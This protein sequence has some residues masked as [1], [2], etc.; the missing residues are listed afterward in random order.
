[1]ASA[2]RATK[3]LS[4]VFELLA[5]AEELM[6]RA[7]ALVKP[8]EEKIRKRARKIWD[9]NGRPSG[10]DEEFWFQAERELQEEELKETPDDSGERA[11]FAVASAHRKA[12]S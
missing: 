5:L 1:M 7:R 12:S 8:A 10:R 11:N 3:S 9:E 4:E 2:V 6:Q